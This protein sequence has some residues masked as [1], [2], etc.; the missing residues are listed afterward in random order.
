MPEPA[1]PALGGPRVAV[2]EDDAA[3]RRSLTRMLEAEGFGVIALGG[4]RS[5][6]PAEPQD[7]VAKVSAARAAKDDALRKGSDPIP[8]DRKAQFLPLS[9]FP[10]DPAYNVA[11]RSEEHTS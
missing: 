1:R 11:A 10:I 9:Y 5:T 4:C 7:F 8:E 3:I 2:I 6:P